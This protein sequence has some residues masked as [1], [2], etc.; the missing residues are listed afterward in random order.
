FYRDRLGLEVISEF[1][2]PNARGAFIRLSGESRM[3][4]ID[5][6]RQSKP[7]RLEP[8]ADD[9]LHI[10]IET[11]DIERVAQRQNLGE[12]RLTSWGAKV[13]ELRDPDGIAVWL[14]EWLNAQGA[15]ESKRP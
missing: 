3:E 5:A 10:V 12:P 15:M 7:M 1:T 14:L 11:D 9:R 13:V 4:L 6:T 2:R 8:T